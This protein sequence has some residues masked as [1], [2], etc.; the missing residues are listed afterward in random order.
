MEILLYGEPILK[1]RC[2][3]VPRVT[4]KVRAL[5]SNMAEAMRQA[6]GLG[7]A[8]PQ[9]GEPSCVVVYDVGQGLVVLINP[10][11]ASQEDVKIMEEGCLSL[12]NLHGE[13]ARAA[14][15]SVQARNLQG[16]RI[17]RTAQ[18]LEAR[19][20]QHECDHL[21]GTLFIDRVR[22]DTLYWAVGEDEN[23]EPYRQPTTLQAAVRVFESRRGKSR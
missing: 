21:E 12:P 15:I 2:H 13:V 11:I 5:V 17:L 18:G 1:Q 9:L 19:V 3:P 8:A 16:R 7:L 14:T 22:P 10:V 6:H 4:P 20:I 23:G